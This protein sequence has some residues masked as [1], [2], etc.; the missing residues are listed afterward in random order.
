MSGAPASWEA[1]TEGVIVRATPRFLDEESD[2]ARHRYVWAYAIEIENRGART[3]TLLT[4]HWRIA[5]RDGRT[6]EVNGPGVV[7]ETPTLA[8]GEGFVYT[9]GCPL[10]APSGVMGGHY[11]FMV[12]DGPET[13]DVRIPMFALDSPYD[14]SR[15]S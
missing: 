10:S 6:Q 5:D 3:I 15:P 13:L 7:G 2:P 11:R 1:E 4:R 14:R 12:E 8:P 9:S